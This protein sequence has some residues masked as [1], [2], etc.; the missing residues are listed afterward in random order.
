MT[1]R[2]Q[3]GFLPDI[4]SAREK[5]KQSKKRQDQPFFINVKTENLRSANDKKKKYFAEDFQKVLV[6]M[7]QEKKSLNQ[8]CND[9]DMPDIRLVSKYAKK[10]MF[11]KRELEKTY[12]K[13]PFSVQAGVGGLPEE[14][15]KKKFQSLLRSGHSSVEIARQLCVSKNS[16]RSRLD[17]LKTS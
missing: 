7:L 2:R 15:F 3:N 14:K 9:D 5:A 12:A 11:F 16:I 1:K 4:D 8:V 17:L 13:L 6:R 10:N